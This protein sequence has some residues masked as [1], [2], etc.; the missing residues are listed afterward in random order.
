MKQMQWQLACCPGR[1]WCDYVS[2]SPQWRED[3]RLMI[4]R[5]P[6]DAGMITSLEN[7]VRVFLHEVDEATA[8]L[9]R[10]INRAV[11]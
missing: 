2:Y 5:V 4:L 6:R 8:A 11:A 9:A 7:E 10:I 1:T 3:L